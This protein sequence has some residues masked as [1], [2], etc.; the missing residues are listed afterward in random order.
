M[1]ILP[2]FRLA[3][4]VFLTLVGALPVPSWAQQPAQTQTSQPASAR[5]AARTELTLCN[6]SA[7]PIEI[8]IVHM[9]AQTGSWTLSAWHKRAASECKAFGPVRTGQF[10]YHARSE[11]GGIWPADRHAERR[12]CVPATAV[13]RDMTSQCGAGETNRPFKG[14]KLETAKYTF[15]FN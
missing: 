7:A 15:T 10:Y 11:R 9:D 13:K 6:K 3:S 12:Y 4:A 1:G 5:N 14:Q 2:D 8:A